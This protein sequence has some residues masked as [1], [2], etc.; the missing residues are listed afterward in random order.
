MLTQTLRSLF[1][2]VENY[3][4]LK[5]NQNFLALQEELTSTENKIGFSRQY[6]NDSVM[7]YNTRI[8][9]VPANV[10]A[11]MSQFRPEAFFEIEDQAE[12]A[13]PQVKF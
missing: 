3:P 7:Q 8:Q 1:A 12:R 9:V 4:D 10:V 5:A 13:A 11:G 2:V 6:Y